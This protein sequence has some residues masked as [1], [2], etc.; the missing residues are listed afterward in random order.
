MKAKK[1]KESPKPKATIEKFPVEDFT[2]LGRLF[3]N[4][5]MKNEKSK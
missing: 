5:N 4:K 3:K 1:E 2:M